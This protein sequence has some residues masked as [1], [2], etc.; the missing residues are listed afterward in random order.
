MA[1]WKLYI[2][3]TSFFVALFPST[4]WDGTRFVK[5][6]S[7]TIDSFAGTVIWIL[8]WVV[9]LGSTDPDLVESYWDLI[10]VYLL[11]VYS[12]T[13]ADGSGLKEET[14]P[15]FGTVVRDFSKIEGIFDFKIGI[16]HL[17]DNWKY[18]SVGVLGPIFYSVAGDHN[19]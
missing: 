2:Q 4:N 19:F 11:C 13:K 18:D 17:H 5:G 14:P 1:I 15:L 8:I 16:G 12:P 10:L 6:K 9:P 7:C 3:E